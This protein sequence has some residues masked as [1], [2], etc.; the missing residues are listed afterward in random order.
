LRLNIRILE[1]FRPPEKLRRQKSTS[2]KH[3]AF[4]EMRDTEGSRPGWPVR[5]MTDKT[6]GK[7][8]LKARRDVIALDF[9]SLN[10]AQLQAVMATEG[11]LLLLAGAGSGK[12]TS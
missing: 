2:W 8:L 9:P 12:T 7:R 11:P 4:I 6:F 10:E 3:G 1:W 5:N